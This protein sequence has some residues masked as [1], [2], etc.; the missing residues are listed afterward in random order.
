TLKLKN[1]GLFKVATAGGPVTD[2]KF[3]E[4]MYGERYMDTPQQNPEGYQQASLLNYA[5]K[6]EGKLLIIHGAQD[7]TVVW[8]NSLELLNKFIEHKKQ[9]DYFVY[10]THEHNVRG[11][12]R[13]HLYRKLATYYDDFL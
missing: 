4:V 9:A 5:D 3:Y 6:L 12:D 7:N 13:A 1:P 8:Q 10:P 2:W 11:L